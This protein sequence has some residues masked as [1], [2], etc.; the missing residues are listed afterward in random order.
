MFVVKEQR[1]DGAP[2]ALTLGRRIRHLRTARGLTLDALGRQV[3]VTPSLLSLFENGRRE[4]RLTLLRSLATAL[5][6]T[7]AD[8]LDAEPPSRRAALEIALDRAQRSARVER[9][10]LPTVRPGKALPLPVLEQLVGLH[11]ELARRDLE[12]VTTP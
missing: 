6:V 3:G 5:D 10:A 4:P 8:L 1:D 9:L 12:A 2:D 7:V 11:S